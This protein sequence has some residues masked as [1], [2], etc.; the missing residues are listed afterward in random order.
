MDPSVTLEMVEAASAAV[1]PRLRVTPRVALILGSGLNTLADE[2]DDPVAIPYAEIPGFVR[3]TVAG[4]SG[5]LVGGT[6]S[7]TPV[8]AMQGR[9]HFY[10]GYTPAQIT[11]PVRV[12]RALGAGIL[13]VT[14]AAGG[15]RAGLVTGDLMAITDHIFFAGLAGHNPL[16]GPND[17]RLGVRFPDMTPAY[18][19]G[20]RAL[21]HAVAEDEDIHTREGVYAMVA[22]PS[23]ETPAEIRLL[24]ALGADA[25]GM[26][27]A[28]EVVVARHSGMRV[29]GLSLITNV[30]E[31]FALDGAA[32]DAMHKQVLTVGASAVP[33]MTRLVR[34]VL[35]RLA[36]AP[37]A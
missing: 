33:R 24:R 23:Y 3:S 34:G 7:G 1:A 12:M 5:R 35:A 32:A 16:R 2:I 14:N 29:L 25:V 17:E 21:L 11:F 30:P 28:P 15:V 36:T 8:I 18:D 27:T 13:V 31:D 20:L 6:L 10:E 37:E 9:F 26:S 19:P 22:G 4:H